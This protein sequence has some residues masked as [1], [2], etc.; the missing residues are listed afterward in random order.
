MSGEDVAAVVDTGTGFPSLAESCD[1]LLFM[2]VRLKL[3]NV[4]KVATGR[5][6]SSSVL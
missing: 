1:S 3:C 6:K 2:E 5:L 4:D